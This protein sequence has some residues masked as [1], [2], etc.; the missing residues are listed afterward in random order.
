M[1]D[2]YTRYSGNT[3]IQGVGVQTKDKELRSYLTYHS[4][5]GHQVSQSLR[6]MKHG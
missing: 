4:G 1:Q 2:L 3:F 6:V 5:L